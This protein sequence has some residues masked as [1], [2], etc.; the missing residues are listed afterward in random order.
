[1]D[2]TDSRPSSSLTDTEIRPGQPVTQSQQPLARRAPLTRPCRTVPPMALG[3]PSL[4]VPILRACGTT[5][6]LRAVGTTS[7]LRAV[8][9]TVLVATTAC[10][11]TAKGHLA[12]RAPADYAALAASAVGVLEHKYYAGAGLWNM[13]LPA[14]RDRKNFDWGA[15]SLTY[16]LAFHWQLTHDRRVV[17]LMRALARTAAR[18]GP[19]GY[20]WSDVPEWDAIADVREYQVTA[21]P[22]ALANAKAAVAAVGEVPG[23]ASGAC[24]VIDYQRPGGEVNHLKTLETGSNYI[25]AAVL[26]YQV[27]HTASYL[28]AA[29]RKYAEV[30]AY[31]AQGSLYTV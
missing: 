15:D 1:M 26:L 8:G 7:I 11:G 13:C 4:A 24:P 28:A 31:F 27:T 5:S 18:Y 12:R 22:A 2:S 14:R 9:V 23:F 20:S 29:E 25:K 10:A 6:I 3:R 30:H 19:T 16:S 21:S 17:P